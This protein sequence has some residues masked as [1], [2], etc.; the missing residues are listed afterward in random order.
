[1]ALAAARGKLIGVIGDEVSL[2][3]EGVF[4]YRTVLR[5]TISIVCLR[6]FDWQFTK[7]HSCFRTLVSG[8][9]LAVLAKS[10][11]TGTPTLWW[12]IKVRPS[13]KPNLL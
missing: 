10:T 7:D 6:L 5:A 12:S 1:M 13:K 2:V 11:R 9:S 8:F 4:F 3:L